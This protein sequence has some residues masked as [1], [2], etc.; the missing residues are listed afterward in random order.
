[1]T[2]EYQDSISRLSGKT[3]FVGIGS[4]KAGTSWLGNY[5]SKH[6]EICFSPIKELHYFDWRFSPENCGGWHQEFCRR[7]R[8]VERRLSEDGEPGVKRM[9]NLLRKRLEMA[10]CPDAYLEYFEQVVRPKHKAFGEISPSYSMMP[11]A[12]FTS[13]KRMLPNP[14]L[15][16]MLRNPADR[17][18]SQLRFTMRRKEG[19]SAEDQFMKKLNDPQFVWRTDYARTMNHLFSEFNRDEVLVIFYEQLFLGDHR[20]DEVRRITDF[21]GVSNKAAN[22][23]KHINVSDEMV[24]DAKLRQKAVRRFAHV[25]R[26]VAEYFGDIPESWQEDLRFLEGGS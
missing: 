5:F 23:E 2:Q 16:W 9:V 21:L 26:A 7:L 14:K 3:C 4:Q 1:M 6:P 20:D 8:K 25:Y 11:A 17:Y 19:F 15:I 12:G 18:W 10:D 13:M 24:L 22:F